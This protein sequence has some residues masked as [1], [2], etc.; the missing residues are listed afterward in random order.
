[1]S[2]PWLKYD[3]EGKCEKEL[4]NKFVESGNPVGQYMNMFN[5]LINHEVEKRVREALEGEKGNPKNC[6]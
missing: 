1:V 4:M 2:K 6:E 3:G 5:D